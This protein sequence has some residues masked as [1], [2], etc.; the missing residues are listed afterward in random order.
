LTITVG[1]AKVGVVVMVGV[2]VMVGVKVVV[3]VNVVSAVVVNVNAGIFVGVG[4]T[5]VA[6]GS[7]VRKLQARM[8]SRQTR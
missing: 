4:R 3:G 2:N 8:A 7:C 5:G 1:K 6:F